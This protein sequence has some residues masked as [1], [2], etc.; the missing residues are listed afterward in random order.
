MKRRAFL[1]SL[2]LAL[3]AVLAPAQRTTV[4]DVVK[5]A[6]LRVDETRIYALLAAD[7]AAL[8]DLLAP[9]CVYVHSNGLAQTK[10]QFLAALKAGQIKYA[11]LRYVAPPQVRLYGETA[12][13]QATAQIEVTGPDGKTLKPTLVITAVYAMVNDRWQLAS[14]QSTTAPAAAVK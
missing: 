6:V 11:S 13:L 4:A 3:A 12:V 10:S 9:D 5:A 7:T 8:D 2:L 1:L 14:Y